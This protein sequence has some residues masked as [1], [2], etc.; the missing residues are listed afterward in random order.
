MGKR[1]VPFRMRND[2]DAIATH[3]E[4]MHE[5]VPP[6]LM[7]SVIRFVDVMTHYEG[8]LR[9]VELD[10]ETP[11]AW[12]PDWRRTKRDFCARLEQD[13]ALALDVLDWC[14]RQIELDNDR[15]VSVNDVLARQ[16]VQQSVDELRHA[17][18]TGG[19][20][21]EVAASERPDG[22]QCYAL[23]DRVPEAV[24]LAAESAMKLDRA[25]E[26]L[27]LA[28]NAAF[29]RSPSPGDAY[30]KA[31]KAVEA[32]ARPILAP[33]DATTTLGKMIGDL[34]TREASIE[35]ALKGACDSSPGNEKDV[36]GV[37]IARLM[38]QLLLRSQHDRH[39]NPNPDAP[40]E[41]SQAEAQAAVH[42][43]VTLVQW[44]S[45]GVIRRA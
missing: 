39:D 35:L 34:K 26:H 23:Q 4:G 24:R 29:G 21:Y 7:E 1:H 8:A 19:S 36:P 41:V 3:L 6:H 13:P 17:L 20:A 15:I 42:L 2:P 28:W 31:L 40:P 22:R 18:T 30:A 25:G 32:A 44:F 27:T 37:T 9:Q 33:N 45:T 10:T 11:M 43:A 12:D 38:I 14:L 16:S 5:G